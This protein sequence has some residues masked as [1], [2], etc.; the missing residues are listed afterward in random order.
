MQILGAQ[1]RGTEA[2]LGHR[3]VRPGKG[4]GG[5]HEDAVATSFLRPEG[6]LMDGAEA[7]VSSGPERTSRVR[8]DPDTPRRPRQAQK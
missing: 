6:F 3:R 2:Y 5:V 4:L 1:A 8:E 7:G